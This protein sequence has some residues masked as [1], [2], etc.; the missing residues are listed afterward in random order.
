MDFKSP[1]VPCTYEVS[2]FVNNKISNDEDCKKFTFHEE[3]LTEVHTLKQSFCPS[4]NQD[5]TLS[6]E[7]ETEFHKCG[8]S[9]QFFET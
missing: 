7:N 1:D 2:L 8:V 4:F 6:K 5:K 9:Y 3:N